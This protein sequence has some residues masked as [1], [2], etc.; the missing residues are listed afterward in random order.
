MKKQLHLNDYFGQPISTGPP[1]NLFLRW[2]KKSDLRYCGDNFFEIL[3]VMLLVFKYLVWS[4]VLSGWFHWARIAEN[5]EKVRL[6]SILGFLCLKSKRAA[7]LHNFC[8]INRVFLC[9]GILKLTITKAIE[10]QGDQEREPK[11]AESI[12]GDKHPLHITVT[13]DPWWIR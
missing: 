11:I 10:S 12:K 7:Y 4:L 9:L 8:Q 3:M 13:F 2:W 5:S 1:F 6:C